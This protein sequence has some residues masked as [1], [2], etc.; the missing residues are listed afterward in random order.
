MK[1]IRAFLEYSGHKIYKMKK[2]KPDSKRNCRIFIEALLNCIYIFLWKI[3]VVLDWIDDCS[4]PVKH[5]LKYL[6]LSIQDQYRK[7]D[8]RLPSLVALQENS[9]NNVE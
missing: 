1:C 7:K 9:Q 5:F 6:S 8:I 3:N 4:F 2:G